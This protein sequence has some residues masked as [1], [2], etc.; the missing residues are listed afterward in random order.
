MKK[1]ITI[2]FAGIAFTS[3]NNGSSKDAAITTSNPQ[4]AAENVSYP[5]T[6]DHP[7]NWETGS[8]QNTVAVLSALKAFEN[9]NMD[10]SMKYFGDSVHVMF[11]GLDSTMSNDALKSMFGKHRSDIKSMNIQ[12]YDWE[13][14]ISKDKK[15]EY[16]TIWYKQKWEDM[17][18]KSDS[19]ALINDCKM[20]NGKIVE[21][22]EFTRRF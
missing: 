2:I 5:Y 15:D 18:G 16:V 20:K 4:V 9:G 21:I 1:W 6:I 14:V 22:S 12:M 8:K 19:V 17:N 7:D 13:P 10:E 3:C 11:D